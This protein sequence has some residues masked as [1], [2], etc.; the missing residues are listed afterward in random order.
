M[1]FRELQEELSTSDLSTAEMFANRTLSRFNIEVHFTNHFREQ[2]NLPRNR[3]QIKLSEVVR[4]FRQVARQQ[5]KRL[6][7]VEPYTK[8]L[9]RDNKTKINVIVNIKQGSSQDKL[10]F[11][12][13]TVIRADNFGKDA[14]ETIFVEAVGRIT[15]QNQ[16]VDV[17]PQ[18]VKKQAAKFGNTVD[19]EGR[20]PSLSKKTKGS[21]TNV[22]YNLGLAES[23]MNELNIPRNQMPQISLDDL[24]DG[25]DLETDSVDPE[26]LETSQD[27]RIPGMVDK[28]VKS[29]ENGFDKPLVIDKNGFIVNGHHRYDA[30]VKLGVSQVPV[31]RVKDASIQELIKDFSHTAKDTY[32]EDNEREIGIHRSSEDFAVID[33]NKS[34]DGT[35]WLNGVD[36]TDWD[37]TV[38][39]GKG[40]DMAF[41]ISS[42]AILASYD[43][44]DKYST[45]ELENMGYDGVRM[46][47]GDNVSYQIW[48]TDILKRT[49]LDENFA[50]GKKK[51]KSRPGRVKRAGA[52][53]NGSVTSLRKKAKNASGEKSKM[54][55]WC[56]N[57]KSGKKK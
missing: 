18:E 31:I 28:T 57:M 41:E 3:P 15:K 16:T 29:I 32:A 55:H 9:L 48:N 2:I 43:D 54:Y 44:I 52:S 14:K 10:L 13:T 35:F 45:G 53:C 25:Y 20:P 8:L 22:L 46:I 27:Q 42:D 23:V 6:E 17:G 24:K 1:R 26:T 30:Y 4:L 51:G 33:L 39:S 47:D 36:N 12:C 11:S 19:K 7:T 38:T 50:D 40:V 49:K 21:K 56:A 34:A 5:G 37:S